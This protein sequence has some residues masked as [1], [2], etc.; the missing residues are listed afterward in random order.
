RVQLSTFEP[1]SEW[2]LPVQ[3]VAPRRAPLEQPRLLAPEPGRVV[4]GFCPEAL[5]LGEAADVRF[6]GELIW[7]RKDASLVQNARDR[8]AALVARHDRYSSRLAD[9]FEA[10][11][12]GAGPG[13]VNARRRKGTRPARAA[14]ATRP[15]GDGRCGVSHRRKARF[16]Q[17]P[18]L[19]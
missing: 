8:T 14:R 18:H 13:G 15:P 5:V 2:R 17:E 16:E 7:R 11:W 9:A 12:Y 6:P 4:L 3:H 10:G 19:Q 1:P